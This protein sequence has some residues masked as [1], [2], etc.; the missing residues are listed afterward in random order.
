MRRMLA[1]G[2]LLIVALLASGCAQ[3]QSSAPTAKV[4]EAGTQE[5]TAAP[6][7]TPANWAVYT[8]DVSKDTCPS[9]QCFETGSQA[10]YNCKPSHWCS[11]NGD[12]AIAGNKPFCCVKR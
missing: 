9:Q 1:L 3:S 8:G 12:K 5:Q 2:V 10:G 4:V 11:V 7:Q 6:A